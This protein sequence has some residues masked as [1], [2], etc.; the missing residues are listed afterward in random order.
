MD[1]EFEPTNRRRFLKTLAMVGVAGQTLLRSGD[2]RAAVGAARDLAV[3]GVA[4]WPEMPERQL[5]NTGFAASRLVFGCGAALSRGP[6]D[7]LLQ[8]SF[9]AGV[10]VYDVGFRSYYKDA[11]Q[12]LAPFARR[13]RDKIF[14]I[15]K[16]YVPTDIEPN[17]SI[18]PGQARYGADAWLEA[19]DGSL[20]ELGVDHLDA[21]YAMASFNPSLI[22]SDELLGAAQ[23]AKDAGKIS[24]LG[25]STHQNAEKVLE[26]AIETGAYSLAQIAVTPA[27]WY[28]WDNKAILPGSPPMAKLRPLF[29]RAR[30]A[31]IGLIGM[32]AGRYLAGRKFLGWGKPTAFDSHYDPSFMAAE[33]S[34]FQRSY[35]FVLEHGLDCVNADSQSMNHLAENF[36]AAATSSRYFG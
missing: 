14:L 15:S 13:V 3:P 21:Y 9:E 16:A 20:R 11:E 26:A 32:K 29:D 30:E 33:F 28:D 6:K 22:Q 31:G 17:Q 2:V 19:L 27:G 34:S 24:H 18:T 7:D 5:G 8:A 10:N 23:R 25:L 12:N 4:N 36:A 35:A 1:I